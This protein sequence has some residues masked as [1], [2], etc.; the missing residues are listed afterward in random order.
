MEL[1]LPAISVHIH[2]WSIMEFLCICELEPCLA[3]QPMVRHSELAPSYASP[4]LR[5]LNE[6]TQHLWF[7]VLGMY[8]AVCCII[9]WA[10]I[11]LLDHSAILDQVFWLCLLC[12]SCRLMSSGAFRW[13]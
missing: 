1:K 12:F 9:W 5:W 4:Y 10:N 6:F 7:R 3:S 11:H 13:T 2:P 8:F